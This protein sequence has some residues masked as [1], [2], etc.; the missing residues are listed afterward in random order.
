MQEL[1]GGTPTANLLTGLRVDGFFA[2][3]DSGGVRNYL[4]D[5]SGSTVALADGSGT[6]QTEYTYEPF[7]TFSTSGAS[8]NS[9]FAFGG[10]EADGTGLFFYRSRYYDPRLHRFIGENA[11]GFGDGDANMYSYGRNNPL[12]WSDPIPLQEGSAAN[13]GR[14]EAINNIA[15]GYD[16]SAAWAPGVKREEFGPNT[17]KCNKFVCDVVREAGAEIVLTTVTPPRC[18]TAGEM[19]NPNWNAPNW[20]A[21]GPGETPQPGDIAAFPIPGGGPGATGH[22]GII[23]GCGFGNMSAHVSGT[24]HSQRGQF[25]P[26]IPRILYRRYTGG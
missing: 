20:R 7:G 8:T 22:S 2:R 10:W 17:N 18:P 9:T 21:L 15:C 1:S 19:A 12:V 25:A 11:V 4:T 26:S 5:A 6:I 14:R 24:V 16:G 23:T 3:T 13:R